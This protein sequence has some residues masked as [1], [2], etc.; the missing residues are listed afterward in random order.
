[1]ALLVGQK[2]VVLLKKVRDFASGKAVPQDGGG[3]TEMEKPTM[4]KG[5]K[6][7]I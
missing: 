5:R 4:D 2:G 1:V 3:E 6:Q 7:R